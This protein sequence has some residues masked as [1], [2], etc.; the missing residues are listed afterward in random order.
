MAAG[1]RLDLRP[2]AP[3]ALEPEAVALDEFHP[4]ASGAKPLV[5]SRAMQT[6]IF[7]AKSNVK[8]RLERGDALPSVPGGQVSIIPLGTGGSC[9]AKDR[10][11][12]L[13]RHLTLL[14]IL[15]TPLL[16]NQKSCLLSLQSQTGGMSCWI[17]GKAPGVS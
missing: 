15:T 10:N 3:P 7:A 2:F 1:M 12:M 14:P 5:L 4:P 11:G 6:R 16:L 8:K 17:S 13:V 9:P